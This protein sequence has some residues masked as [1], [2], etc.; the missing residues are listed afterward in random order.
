MILKKLLSVFVKRLGNS[1]TAP[2]FKI[3]IL[4]RL[5]N[6]CFYIQDNCFEKVAKHGKYPVLI[7]K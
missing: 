6:F 2:L 3:S 5:L 1:Y 4:N 7:V